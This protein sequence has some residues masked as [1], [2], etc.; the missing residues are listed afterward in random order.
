[1]GINSVL[2]TLATIAVISGCAGPRETEA[3]GISDL[4]MTPV[5][6][7]LGGILLDT[8]AK[9]NLKVQPVDQLCQDVQDPCSSTDARAKCRNRTAGRQLVS[10]ELTVYRTRNIGGTP[11]DDGTPTTNCCVWT[12]YKIGGINYPVCLVAPNAAGQCP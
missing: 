2:V 7:R 10:G 1:M 5:A 11:W 12:V 6:C 8:T 3:P 9:N 4:A